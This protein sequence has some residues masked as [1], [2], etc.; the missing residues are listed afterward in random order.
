VKPITASTTIERPQEELF[1]LIEDLR[2]HEAWTDH[3]LVDWSGDASRVKVRAKTPGP[4]DWLDIETLS[5]ERP[6]KTVERTT[7]A[8][9]K[10]ISYGT[11]TLRL[12]SPSSTEV[13]FELRI[14]TMPRRER[15]LAPLLRPYLQRVNDKAMKRLKEHAESLPA[16]A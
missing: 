7:G 15:V 13:S 1:D 2:R 6:S 16:P 11:Y 10:R 5:V 8:R 3:M 9:G 12:L 4:A 14:E